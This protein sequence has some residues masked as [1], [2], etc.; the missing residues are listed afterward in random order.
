MLPIIQICLVSMFNVGSI[1]RITQINISMRLIKINTDM[2]KL[3]LGSHL[4]IKSNK[5]PKSEVLYRQNK[6][7]SNIVLT[8]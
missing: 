8:L 7:T 3:F 1:N 4:L 2:S 5:F 6:L